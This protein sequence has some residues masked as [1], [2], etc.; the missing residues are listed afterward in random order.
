MDY[1]EKGTL[2]PQCINLTYFFLGLRSYDSELSQIFKFHQHDL[3]PCFTRK[4]VVDN[5]VEKVDRFNVAKRKNFSIIT[6]NG[7]CFKQVLKRK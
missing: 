4:N 6:T 2:K 5:D 1:K 7:R 3:N